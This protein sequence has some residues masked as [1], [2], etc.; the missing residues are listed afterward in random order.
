MKKFFI[1]G[2]LAPLATLA[3]N[4]NGVESVEYD[5]VNH[6]YLASRGGNS[7]RNG[8]G[9]MSNNTSVQRKKL[10]LKQNIFHGMDETSN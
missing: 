3:Q 8:Y 4:L 7:I 2:L 10:P 1:V 9:N 6:Q 5:P